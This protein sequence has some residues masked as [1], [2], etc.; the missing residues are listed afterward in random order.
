[1]LFSRCSARR[2]CRAAASPAFVPSVLCG[3]AAVLR[4]AA[5]PV[6]PSA[7]RCVPRC[8]S[9]CSPLLAPSG[10]RCVPRCVPRSCCRPL[11]RAP[12]CRAAVRLLV[13]SCALLGLGLRFCFCFC[14]SAPCSACCSAC[15]LV[16]PLRPAFR[17]RAFGPLAVEFF[18][19]RSPSS[20]SCF[21]FFFVLCVLRVL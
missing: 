13:R 14:C 9:A 7:L 3:C 12:V 6:A 1:M 11:R 10:P 18:A 4:A 17:R 16:F 15:S 19:L 21:C 5:L 20:S 2:W 8:P